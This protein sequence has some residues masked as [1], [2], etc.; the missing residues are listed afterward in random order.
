MFNLC[1]QIIAA[2]FLCIVSSAPAGRYVKFIR[3]K[4]AR[5]GF[6]FEAHS[7]VT[8]DGYY[9]QIFRIYSPEKRIDS[10]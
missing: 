9:L 4:V 1:K 2:L 8:E 6:N 3:D 5:A 10:L 7:V